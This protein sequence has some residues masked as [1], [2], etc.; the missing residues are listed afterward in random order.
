MSPKTRKPDPFEQWRDEQRAP[1][2]P[3]NPPPAQ[4]RIR[5]SPGREAIR[6]LAVDRMLDARDSG[7]QQAF[8]QV[9]VELVALNARLFAEQKAEQGH[10]PE[11]V[12]GVIAVLNVAAEILQVIGQAA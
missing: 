4:G 5:L 2:E 9:T 3:Q 11:T 7:D 10:I 8:D 6:D 12:E 1:L